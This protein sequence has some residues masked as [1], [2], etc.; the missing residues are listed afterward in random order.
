M[1]QEVEA[2]GKGIFWVGFTR[3]RLN[4]YGSKIWP[5]GARGGGNGKI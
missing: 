2:M 3:T 5:K 4:D 1:A